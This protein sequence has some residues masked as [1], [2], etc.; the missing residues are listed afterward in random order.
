VPEL[1]EVETVR[2]GL[3]AHTCQQTL[4]GGSV[5]LARTLAAPRDPETFL[6]GLNGRRIATWLRRG[7]YLIAQLGDGEPLDTLQPN[8]EGWLGVHLRMTGQLLWCHPDDPLQ[9]HA[10]VRL[11]FEGDRE[12]RFVDTRTFGR[13][14]WVPP[15]TRPEAIITGLLSLGPEPF[16]PDFSREYLVETLRNRRKPIKTALLD[17]A[18]VAGTGNIYA[19]ETLFLSGIPPTRLCCELNPEEVQRLRENLVR[20]LERAIETGGT[21]L[22]DFRDVRG[23]NGNYGGEA[24]VYNRTGEPCRECGT[25]IERIKLGGRSAHFCPVCQ[26]EAGT[27]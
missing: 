16:S 2:R 8:P 11:Y 14:W 4:V 18:I 26:P 19:D 23:L 9:K 24:W 5:L 22:R 6:A 27:A 15:D 13:M 12:L 1:P 17:Q 10:R 3:D 7:K 21:T 20:V 25:P